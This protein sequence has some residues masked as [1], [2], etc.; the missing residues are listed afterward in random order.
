MIYTGKDSLPV[1]NPLVE[2]HVDVEG[3]EAQ[4]PTDHLRV[5]LGEPLMARL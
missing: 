3:A 1:L 4:L 5:S 2:G